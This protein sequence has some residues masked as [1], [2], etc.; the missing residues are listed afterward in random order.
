MDSVQAVA[1]D[2][3][4]QKQKETQKGPSHAWEGFNFPAVDENM[5]FAS[6][7]GALELSMDGVIFEHVG[8]ILI[9]DEWI[10]DSNEFDVVSF[11]DDAGNQASNTPEAW[12]ATCILIIS[13]AIATWGF[14]EALQW[15]NKARGI[16]AGE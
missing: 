2:T 3:V 4:H 13:L 1:T 9:A 8:Q 12:E 6:L 11:K 14:R 5:A 10:V 16:V 15:G 7:K